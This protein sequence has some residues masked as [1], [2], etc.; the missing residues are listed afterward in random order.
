ME[1]SVIRSA[2]ERYTITEHGMLG[3]QL[4][5]LV[6]VVCLIPQRLRIWVMLAPDYFPSFRVH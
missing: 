6:L 4:S 1:I 5:D 3:S 2:I